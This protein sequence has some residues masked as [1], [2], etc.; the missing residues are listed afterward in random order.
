[1]RT[2]TI[3]AGRNAGQMRP[4]NDLF[5]DAITAAR[6]VAIQLK[7]EGFTVL[8]SEI[9]GGMAT[10]QVE[11]GRAT[12]E[13]VDAGKAGYTR[14]ETKDGVRSKFGQFHIGNCRVVFVEKGGH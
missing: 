2:Q 6:M 14:W 7:R 3:N 4:V 8:G 13:M 10:I 1:M 9:T 11:S 12:R 5:I